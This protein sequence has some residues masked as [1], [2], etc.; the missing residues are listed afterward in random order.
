LA[1]PSREYRGRPD[2]ER[3]SPGGIGA[4]DF[5]LFFVCIENGGTIL[6]ADVRTLAV[7][8]GGVVNHAEE[9]HQ[10]LAVGDARRIVDDADTF[11]MAGRAR[12]DKIVVRVCDVAAAVSGCSLFHA[13]DMFVDSLRSPKAATG[14]DSDLLGRFFCNWFVK[15]GCG[16]GSIGFAWHAR[17]GADAAPSDV[18]Y[19]G[20]YYESS[21]ES[22]WF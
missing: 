8:L 19:Q 12:A 7:F 1:C 16:Q 9:N 10:K 14:K 18:T 22:R 20:D 6:L 5:L 4:G 3:G 17:G 21:R 2:D 13:D 15:R 11:R